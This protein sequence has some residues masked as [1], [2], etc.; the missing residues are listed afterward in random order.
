[1]GKDFLVGALVLLSWTVSL[2]SFSLRALEVPEEDRIAASL[3][4]GA[5]FA[6]LGIP[7]LQLFR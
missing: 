2:T 6:M 7:L 1:M 5:A 4:L 3:S